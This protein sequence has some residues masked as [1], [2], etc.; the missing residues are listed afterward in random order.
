MVGIEVFADAWI[1]TRKLATALLNLLALTG[2]AVHIGGWAAKVRNYAGK[3]IDLVSYFHDLIQDR[4]FRTTLDNTAFVFS[5]RAERTTTE[6]TAHDI[7]RKADHFP[8]RDIGV[9]V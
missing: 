7:D 5:D 3:T 4:F 1:H 8:C 6:A 9:F 2:D